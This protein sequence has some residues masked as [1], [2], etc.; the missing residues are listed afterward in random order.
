MGK[1]DVYGQKHNEAQHVGSGKKGRFSL[2]NFYF[3]NSIKA[4]E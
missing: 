1:G 3:E 4:G 2:G